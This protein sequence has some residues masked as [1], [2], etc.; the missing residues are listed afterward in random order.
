MSTTSGF[1]I[2]YNVIMKE[3]IIVEEKDL[4]I[5]AKEL[6]NYLESFNHNRASIVFLDGDLGSGKT[7]FSKTFAKELGSEERVISPTFILKKTYK[8]AHDFFTSLTHIDAYRLI[9]KKEGKILELKDDIKDI[10]KIILIE[11]PYN[12]A[13]ISPDIILSFEIVDE[14]KR[15]ILISYDSEE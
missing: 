5:V 10:N 7:T 13:K 11:W 2:C 1:V 15:K 12:L 9:D 3:E 4:K 14:N 8:T 6:I